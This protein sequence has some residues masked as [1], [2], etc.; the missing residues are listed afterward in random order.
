MKIIH[1]SDWHLGHTLHGYD[2]R[3]EQESMLAQMEEIVRRERPDLF[4]VSGD[5]FDVSQ[6]S[7][8]AQRMFVDTVMRL[9]AAHPGMAIVITAGN[10]DSGSRHEIFRTPMKEFGVELVGT[11]QSG[12]P[13]DHIIELPGKGFVVA[14]PY[15]HERNIPEGF[16]Q[17]VLDIA[18][19]RNT[20]QLPVIMMAHTTVKG[21]DFTGHKSVLT[22][23]SEGEAREPIS[24][25]GI[26]G[27]PVE[28][29]GEGYDYLALGHI[30]KPQFIHTGKHNVRYS[31]SP[32][33]V[34][35]DEDYAHSVTMVEIEKHGDTPRSTLIEINNPWPLVTL[36][37]EGAA[38]WAT[39]RDLLQNF[40]DDQQAYIRLNVMVTDF[41]PP[42]ANEEAFAITE[43]KSCRFCLIN[44]KRE[45]EADHT[46][47]EMTLSEFR[48]QNPEDIAKIFI[49]ESG[50]T[51]DE[52]MLEMFRE[53]TDRLKEEEK[54]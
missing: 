40:P 24:I 2:R 4:L 22:A 30:H 44:S 9:H 45:R 27:T 43:G 46:H 32:L 12:F 50:G 11:L 37:L 25:G 10:H 28:N 7:S 19:E 54:K 16:I 18:N 21:C 52:G 29:M 6:P 38:D 39:A 42:E 23:S 53:A 34:S 20:G 51:F 8:A 41:L 49:E 5:V 13:E 48:N 31:G 1:T 15:A 47:R 3:E 17:S 33:A 36:P 26:D 14:L 35:F